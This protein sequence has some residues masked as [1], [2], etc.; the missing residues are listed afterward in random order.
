M[1]AR[2]LVYAAFVSGLLLAA[3]SP[4]SYAHRWAQW[5][6]S[7]KPQAKPANEI[8]LAVGGQTEYVIVIPTAPT[9]QEQKAAEELS[10]WLGEMTAAQFPVVSDVQ[11][12]QDKE[13]SVGRTSRLAGAGLAVARQDLGEGYAIAVRGEKIYLLGGERTGPLYAVSALLEEDLGCRWYARNTS[14]IPRR[15]KLSFRPVPRTFVPILT[16]RRD[17]YYSDCLDAD[18]LLRNRTYGLWVHIPEEWGGY[19]KYFGGRGGLCHTFNQRMPRTEFFESHPEYFSEQGGQ[20]NS[21]Q[22]CMT[23]PDVKR[24]V[25]GSSRAIRS[26]LMS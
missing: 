24:I 15:P 13:I 4:P 25:S 2:Y 17:P 18:W 16:A 20:R 5:H 11:P 21:R 6:N 12:A 14:T 3:T 10:L 8:A 22:L 26:S 19:P 9:T 7:L 1:M 23:H